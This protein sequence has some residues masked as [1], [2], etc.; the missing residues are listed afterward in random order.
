HTNQS[1]SIE[2]VITDILTKATMEEFVTNDQ[3]NYYSGIT[4]IMGN[5]K[6]AYELKGKFLDDLC[7][8]AF[9]GTNEEDT[10]GHIGYFLK[11]ID[12]IYLPNVNHE[13]LRLATFP[14]SLVGNASK[15]FDEIKGSITTW[16]DL[17]KNLFGKYY[18]PSR[19]GKMTK[20][21]AK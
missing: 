10:V 3:A 6:R 11:I 1:E 9:S 14:I 12:L 16:V 20:T 7:D 21:N 19:T 15:W 13:R 5:G 2:E 18:P 4:N 8:N 17:T